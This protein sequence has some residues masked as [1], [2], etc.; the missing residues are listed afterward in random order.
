MAPP[1]ASRLRRQSCAATTGTTM[2]RPTESSSVAQG[3]VID[4][5]P[6]SSPTTGAK[7]TTMIMSF[8]AT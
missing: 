2:Y 3:T 6:S 1:P 8:S 5:R 7:A 4:D